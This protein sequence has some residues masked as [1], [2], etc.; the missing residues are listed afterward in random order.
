MRRSNPA[1]KSDK[2]LVI[3]IFVLL[4]FGL[5][6]IYNATAYFSQSALQSAFRFVSLQL[7][8][9]LIGLIGFFFFARYDYKKLGMLSFILFV[10]TSVILLVL[11]FVG[12]FVCT[13]ETSTG[14][15]FV[16]CIN[17]ASRWFYINPPPFPAVP[18]VGVVGFQPGELAKL[19]IIL[20]LATQLSK[21]ERNKASAHDPFIV[22]LVTSLFFALLL[23]FQPNM[24][25]AVLVFLIGSVVYFASDFSIIPQLVSMPIL[26]SLG[27]LV[28]LTS[29]YRRERFLTLIGI[30]SGDS[31]AAGYH[32]KQILIALGSGGLFGVGFGQSRQK[33]QYLPEIASDSIF[34]IIGEEFGF[35][36]TLSVLLAFGYLIF[37]GITIA[38]SAPDMLGRMLA[39]GIISWIGIQFFINVAAMTK[40]I[41]LTGVPMPL[42][43]Y[44]GS[45]MVISLVGLG[46]L[47]NIQRQSV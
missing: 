40:L 2:K 30:N 14:I 4:T 33:Y 8:W 32:I 21:F 9:I 20:Y 47:Q 15:G 42:I 31:Q 28:M 22:Y 13:A 36:G 37:L 3:M 34:A 17:G 18:F 23:F 35:I 46:I 26:G 27:F 43:S 1:Q 16:P 25:T 12:V 11:G 5:V 44:G 7:V 29:D 6:V 39:T 41:P 45:S 10:C 38:K 24:S 19:V